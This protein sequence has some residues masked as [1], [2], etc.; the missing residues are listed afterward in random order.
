[1]VHLSEEALS[2]L[3]DGYAVSGAE[4]HLASCSACRVEL[5]ALR[6]L[7]TDLRDLAN[8]EAPPELWARIAAGLPARRGWR[9]R[10]PM[11]GP[12]AAQAVA[13]AAVFVLGLGLGAIFDLGDGEAPRSAAQLASDEP[14]AESLA[15]A[16]AVV[17]RRGGEYDTALR[18]LQRMAAQQGAPAPDLARQRLVSLDLLVEASRTALA[19]EPADP[20]LNSYLFAALEEREAVLRELQTADASGTERLWR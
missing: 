19:A 12:V 13:M 8:L 9:A 5:E 20:V 3:V 11:P 2:E 1:M 4:E 15:E 6:R 14:A 17:R 7:R 10:L 18:A 16:L